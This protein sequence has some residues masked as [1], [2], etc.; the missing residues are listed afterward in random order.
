MLLELLKVLQSL[1][2]T[3]SGSDENSDLSEDE[4][5]FF[6]ESKYSSSDESSF[7]PSTARKY[8]SSKSENKESFVINLKLYHASSL[9]KK[10][11][12]KNRSEENDISK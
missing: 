5:I 10:N 8:F 7:I 12:K 9:R 4:Y 6:S 1:S 3:E 2:E 11:V